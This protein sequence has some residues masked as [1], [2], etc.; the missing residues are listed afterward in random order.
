M[1]TD[2][3]HVTLC[4]T[5]ATRDRETFSRSLAAF[6]GLPEHMVSE[7]RR[8]VSHDHKTTR[9]ALE[10]ISELSFRAM[11][12]GALGKAAGP[13][14]HVPKLHDLCIASYATQQSLRRSM[15]D[16]GFKNFFWED[17]VLNMVRKG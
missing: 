5:F 4:N 15:V 14:Q 6:T 3:L 9:E 16:L 2:K 1:D 13:G 17:V 8:T 11:L 7:C 10:L 12:F